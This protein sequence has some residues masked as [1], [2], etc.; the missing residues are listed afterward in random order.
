MRFGERLQARR[1]E[2]GI[3]RAELAEQLEVSPSAVSNYEKNISFPKETV[4]LRL[5]DALKMEP[6]MLFRD[7]YHGVQPVYSQR[8][9]KLLE[10]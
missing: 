10:R 3:S 9:R 4:L 1:E 2:L 6:N 8:E 7:S 5:F